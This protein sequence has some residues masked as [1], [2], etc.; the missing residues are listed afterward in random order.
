MRQAHTIKDFF[1]F[2]R[3]RPWSAVLSVL[4]F[5]LS[6]S[7]QSQNLNT[8]AAH[9]KLNF[10]D[11][12]WR[13]NADSST[14][15]EAAVEREA[16]SDQG[17]QA[18]TKFTQFYNKT[19]QHYEVIEAYTLKADGRKIPVEKEGM[20]VQ[21]GVATGGTSASW[22]DGEIMQITFPNV[23][24]GDHTGWRIRVTTHT[25]ALPG[26]ASLE[27]YLPPTLQVDRFNAT[28]QAPQ[29]LD[30]QVV[31]VGMHMTT[32]QREKDQVWQITGENKASLVEGNA[33]NLNV[34]VPRLLA[35]TYK[36]PLQLATAFSQQLNARLVLTDE[37]RKTAEQ[38][39]QD[40]VTEKQKV[41][42]IHRWIRKN[43]RYVAVY[44]GAGGWVPHDVGWILKNA[45]GDCKDHVL[46]MQALLKAVGIEAVP[47]LINTTN[48]YELAELPMGFNHCIIY[49]PDLDLFADPS[50]SRIPLEALPW[51]DSDKPVVVALA[52]GAKLMRTPVFTSTSNR[53]TVRTHLEITKGGKA[54]GDIT[55][56]AM[57]ATA[58][59][60]QDRLAQI[61][62]DMQGIAV[63]KMLGD[64]HLR[65]R[66]LAQYP[67]VQRDV[68]VQT[69]KIA[70]LEIDNLLNDP[71]AGSI[72]PN[73]ALSLPMYILNNTGNY[74]AARRDYPFTCVPIA[75]REEFELKFDPAFELLRIP[76]DFQESG[77]DGIAFEAHYLR[78]GNSVKGWREMTL[79]HKHHVCSPA[80]FET[81]RPA[82]RRII[83]H[84]RSSILYQQ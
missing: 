76:S 35:S 29:S 61:P 47:V 45:Y 22:P 60:L 9:L 32:A 8:A 21:S 7:A 40:A 57:G 67:A 77:P 62:A 31:A 65:G 66:G 72:N 4:L 54:T 63:E 46:L 16:L 49:V 83:Q 48:N 2:N 37:L 27:E 64:S 1:A 58:T 19:L 59:T 20:Q 78:E 3:L 34:T 24:R 84:L 38:I 56:D 82:M 23:Q 51:A 70:D 30:L 39:T 10:I 68:Q 13:V 36:A 28:V 17:A 25:P 71:A 18:T 15:Y 55:L 42:A 43:I 33:A 12:N 50:D 75:V 80:D 69:L 41:A 52:D 79:S 73:P 26:W 53:V 14:V 6:S 11:L 5:C 81:R 74:T 44:L